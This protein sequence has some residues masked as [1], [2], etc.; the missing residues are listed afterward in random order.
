M[1]SPERILAE[2]RLPKVFALLSS[3][4][5]I[6]D[7]KKMDLPL[8][9]FEAVVLVVAFLFAGFVR[10]SFIVLSRTN[11]SEVDYYLSL[12]AHSDRAREALGIE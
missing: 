4:A 8:Y 11:P 5:L 10:S 9:Q 2:L 6:V 3:I 7:K 12:E 1:I